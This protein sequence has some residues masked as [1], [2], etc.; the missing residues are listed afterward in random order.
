M[1]FIKH[2]RVERIHGIRPVESKRQDLVL[3]LDLEGFICFHSAKISNS[4]E[5]GDRCLVRVG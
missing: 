1:E 4:C 3:Y 2:P 5:P